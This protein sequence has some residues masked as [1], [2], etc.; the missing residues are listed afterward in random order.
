MAMKYMLSGVVVLAM[1]AAPAGAGM[2]YDQKLEQAAMEIVA[3]RIG[4]IRGGFSYAQK[5]ELVIRPGEEE[6]SGQEASRQPAGDV[7]KGAPLSG[8]SSSITTF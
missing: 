4:D 2:R 7:V 3:S 8:R 5:I 1:L 6:G